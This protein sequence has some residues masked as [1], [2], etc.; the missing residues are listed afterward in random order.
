LRKQATTEY[1]HKLLSQ[2]V[3]ERRCVSSEEACILQTSKTLSTHSDDFFHAVAATKNVRKTAE[4]P[5]QPNIMFA[6]ARG[7]KSTSPPLG[8]EEKTPASDAGV[9]RY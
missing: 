3:K 2:L 9:F 6:G 7:R 8:K 4:K 5:R 1:P